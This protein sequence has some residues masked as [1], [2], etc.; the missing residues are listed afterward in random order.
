MPTCIITVTVHFCQN[1]ASWWTWILRDWERSADM[2]ALWWRG[3]LSDPIT[4]LHT[5]ITHL[6]WWNVMATS[7]SGWAD[8]FNL[9]LTLGLCWCFSPLARPG[10]SHFHELL[11]SRGSLCSLF[12]LIFSSKW[13]LVFTRWKKLSLGISP[14]HFIWDEILNELYKKRGWHTQAL[15]TL[16]GNWNLAS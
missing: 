8:G 12:I 7:Q 5:V 13:K 6:M 9:G 10:E 2:T 16:S 14:L 3:A 15:G 11:Q 4:C 1:K